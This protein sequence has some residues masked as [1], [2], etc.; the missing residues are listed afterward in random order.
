MFWIDWERGD[1]RAG[2]EKKKKF[3]PPAIVSLSLSLSLSHYL[4]LTPRIRTSF[5]L[6]KQAS[7]F[8]IPTPSCPRTQSH[9]R[10][11]SF[12]PFKILQP[13][14]GGMRGARE[15]DK[16]TCQW[17]QFES[18]KSI[19]FLSSS[20]KAPWNRGNTLVPLPDPPPPPGPPSP[21]PLPARNNCR[22]HSPSLSPSPR[23]PCSKTRE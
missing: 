14:A 9:V 18:I 10:S 23:G 17:I 22:I 2:E 12:L 16:F 21:L 11:L 13:I 5:L 19:G 1:R 7:H 15:G 6:Q 8:D 20:R 4:S 3:P